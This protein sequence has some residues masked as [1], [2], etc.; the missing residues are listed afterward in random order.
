MA[1]S[2][3]DAAKT[4]YL[5]FLHKQYQKGTLNRQQ[6]EVLTREGYIKEGPTIIKMT[7]SQQIQQKKVK[8]WVNDPFCKPAEFARFKPGIT[9]EDWLPESNLYH[10]QDFIDWI[11]SITYGPFPQ[12][13][14]YPKFEKYKAQA[15]RWL[16]EKD[17]ITNYKDDDSKREYTN[18]ERNRIKENTLYFANKYGELKEGDAISG[19]MKYYAKEHHAVIYYLFDCRYNVIGGKGRQ[20]GFTSAMGIIALK[21]ML[22]HNNYYIKFIAEDKDTVEEI[23][24]DKLKYPFGALPRWLQP[25]VKSDSGTRFWLSDKPGKGKRGYPNSR[26]DVVA[27]KKTAIN[28]GSPQLA[29]VDEIGNIGIL[30]PMLNEARPTMFWNDPK[31]G[32]FTLRRQIWMWGTG[33]EMDKGKGAYEKEWYRILGLWEAKQFESGFVPLFFSWHSRLNK[34]EYEKE[35]AWYY[36]SRSKER[37]IDLE[38]SKIQFHQHYPSS[39]KDMF[40]S[41]SSTL[42]SREIIE[43]GLERCRLMGPRA[44]PTLGY[45]EPIYDYDD[46]MPPESDVPY[47]IIDARFV[48]LDEDDPDH[49]HKATTWMFQ[50]PEQFWV[51]RYWQ[52]TDPIATETGHSKMSSAIWDDHLKTCPALVNFRKQHDHKYAFLQ[53][54]LL[55]LYY[56]VEN[57]VKLGVKELIEANIGTNYSDYKESKGFLNSLIFNTQLPAKVQ[58]GT[59]DIGLDKKGLRA[60]AVIEYMTEV[61]RNYHHNIYISVFFD[62]LSTFAYKMSATGKET[63]EPLNKLMHYD[64]ALDALTYAYIAR[65]ACSHMRT[66]RLNSQFSKTRIRYKLVRDAD[67]NLIRVPVKEINNMHQYEEREDFRSP[68]RQ[69]RRIS[70]S[71]PGAETH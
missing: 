36:G 24:T 50:K 34:E 68:Q 55:G 54:V 13:I 39:F 71:L 43:G 58:G 66:Y 37:D 21:M 56:D 4:R 23:F 5:T 35:K 3:K 70:E 17:N 40:L 53:V 44:R 67:F 16:Q 57:K 38:T 25:P 60:D 15:Y 20:I 28:G 22:I 64:D 59:R 7:P 19:M 2:A 33:G 29:L 51:N 9:K 12:A 30:G 31:T 26:V 62:Q 18:Q 6:I 14:K 61:F 41:N 27:P 48:A 65:I 1:I 52:G 8:R 63:W 46:P 32:K 45:F 47:R 42:V 69:A 49:D 11:N 10:K